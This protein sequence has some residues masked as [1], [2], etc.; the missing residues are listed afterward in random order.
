M[1]AGYTLANREIYIVLA[2]IISSF[3][4]SAS[5]ELDVDPLTGCAD[6][7]HQAMAPKLSGLYFQPRNMKELKEILKN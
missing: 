3:H 4:I 7:A 5:S 6:P 2:R 1:C